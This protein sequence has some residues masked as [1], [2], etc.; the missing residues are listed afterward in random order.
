MQDDAGSKKILTQNA[1]FI[2]FFCVREE[3]REA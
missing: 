2:Y 3:R 1:V